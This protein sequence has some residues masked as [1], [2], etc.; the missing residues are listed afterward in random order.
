MLV[1]EGAAKDELV[2]EAKNR[3]LKNFQFHPLQPYEDLPDLLR[4]ADVHLVVQK[5]GAADAVLPSK[6]TSILAVG[7]NAV[8]TAEVDTELGRLHA[9]YPGMVDLVEPEDPRAM[10]VALEE[11]FIKFCGEGTNQLAREYAKKFL[12]RD[13]IL[14]QILTVLRSEL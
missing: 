12:R 3:G 6:L 1:G 9:E 5:K 13:S 8:I 2:A 7:G 4:S 14:S 10:E 11:Q